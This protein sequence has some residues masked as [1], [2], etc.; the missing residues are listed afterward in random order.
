MAKD[1]QKIRRLEELYAKIPK[2]ECRPGC[3]ECCGPAVWSRI[4]WE[5]LP[6]NMRR[7]AHSLTCP[8][9]KPDGNCEIYELRPLVCRLFGAILRMTCPY[10]IPEKLLTREEEDAILKEYT[11]ISRE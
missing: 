1:N 6:E 7:P 10:T 4:E 3:A 11:E 9:S 5:R 2:V 8:Y